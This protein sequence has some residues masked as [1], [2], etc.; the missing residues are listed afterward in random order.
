MDSLK[1]LMDKK[2]YALVLKL[3]ENSVDP[4]YLFYRISALLATGKAEESLACIKAN[5]ELLES[6]LS[7]L[8]RVH[9]EILCLLG[10]FDEAYE[11]LKHY[12]NLPYVSQQVEELLR[13]MPQYIRSEEKKS[14]G[15]KEMNDDQ[16]IKL[17]RSDDM[18]DV[19]IAL[20]IVKSRK[21]EPFL[22]DLRALMVNH[23]LQSIRSFTLFVLVQNEF[24]QEVAFKHIDE[25][26]HVVPANLEPPFSTN[27]FNNVVRKI[28]HEYKNPSLEETAIQILSTYIM[29]IYPDVIAYSDEVIIEALFQIGNTYLQTSDSKDLSSRCVE[30]KISLV[31]VKEL[32]D[33]INKALNDF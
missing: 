23:P 19:L 16:V 24:K 9:M 7:I 10:R 25:I 2:Q 21:I 30:K 18:N 26:I 27:Q 4:T 31:E 29:Y 1:T 28:S 13:S 17:L 3:T 6:N 8:I 5:R 14:F 12:E 15:S 22:N 11:E 20:D 32:I 33:K